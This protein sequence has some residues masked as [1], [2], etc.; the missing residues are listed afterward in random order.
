MSAEIPAENL[1]WIKTYI[2]PKKAN[3]LASGV[4]MRQ[5]MNVVRKIKKDKAKV[6]FKHGLAMR[7]AKKIKKEES[8]TDQQETNDAA[9]ESN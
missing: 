7:T 5:A 8:V 6:A 4:A 1:A 2:V 9:E 3:D